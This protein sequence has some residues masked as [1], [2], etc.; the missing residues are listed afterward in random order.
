MV[1]TLPVPLTLTL[2][3]FGGCAA[4]DAALH[5]EW[6]GRTHKSTPV[7]GHTLLTLA[8]TLAAT[9]AATLAPTLALIPSLY[10]LRS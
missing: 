3:L 9:L 5:P 7:A 10:Q 6:P 4:A 8:P 2:T 1:G